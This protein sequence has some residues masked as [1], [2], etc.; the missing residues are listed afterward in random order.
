MMSINAQ[1]L[2]K[3]LIFIGIVTVCSEVNLVV[4]EFRGWQNKEALFVGIT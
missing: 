4:E 2:R 1:S 3:F